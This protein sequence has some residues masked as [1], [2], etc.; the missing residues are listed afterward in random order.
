MQNLKTKKWVWIL[1]PLS[2]FLFSCLLSAQ[3]PFKKGNY[4]QVITTLEPIKGELWHNSILNERIPIVATSHQRSVAQ[5][6]AESATIPFYG[7]RVDEE[8]QPIPD[9]IAQVPPNSSRLLLLFQK[10]KDPQPNG[11]LYKV[12]SIKDDLE[13]FPTGTF[14][15]YNFSSSEL[16]I[17]IDNKNKLLAPKKQ[18]NIPVSPPKIGDIWVKMVV[19]KE[20]K[21]IQ[22]VYSNGWYHRENLRTL[23]FIIQDPKTG[24]IKPIR[25]KQ[26]IVKS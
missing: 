14:Q 7:N 17:Y 15:F 10:N 5:K 9:A 6:Y 8:D 20:K 12:I 2:Y 11:L 21:P 19:I 25:I 1:S 4:F 23:V 16:G 24:R 22:M 18:T 13:S 3:T 26:T